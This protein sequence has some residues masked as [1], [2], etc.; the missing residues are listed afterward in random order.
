[1]LEGWEFP[2]LTVYLVAIL[3]LLVMWQYYQMQIMAGRILAVDIF[4]RS[5]IRMYVYVVPDD[6]H[7]CEVCV[8]SNGRVFLPSQVAKKQFS[9]L[10][11]TCRRAAHCDGALV[12]L[13]GA[14]SEA[15]GLLERLRNNTKKGGIQ[16]SAEELR[17]LVN[18]QWERGI[19]ADTDRLGVHMIE[20]FT[21]EKIDPDVSIE[22]YRYV[23]DEA[24]E[25][26][27]LLFLAPAYARFTQLLLQAGEEAEALETIERFERRFPSTKRG[28]HFPS[29]QQREIM[30]TQ[31]ELLLNGP[32]LEMSA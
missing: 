14:W 1:M 23:V 4:D 5:G 17:A 25:V 16:L 12:G 10:A 20:A 29:E 32:P 15:R 13:Y 8:Q 7:I 21:Y 22:G 6:D 26:R 27:H 9:P 30:K 19:S 2:D 11:G 28:P 31:K 24:R 3:G 18:G